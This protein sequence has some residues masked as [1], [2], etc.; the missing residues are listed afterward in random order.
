MQLSNN[1]RTRIGHFR[2]HLKGKENRWVK[3]YRNPLVVPLIISSTRQ[4]GSTKPRCVG[5]KG[6]SSPKHMATIAKQCK[7]FLIS[8]ATYYVDKSV[9]EWIYEINRIDWENI[10][11]AILRTL[12]SHQDPKIPYNP[13]REGNTHFNLSKTKF[14]LTCANVSITVECRLRIFCKMS[15][16]LSNERWSFEK[17]RTRFVL[18]FNRFRARLRIFERM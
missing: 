14:H 8:H 17:C 13:W 3:V 1:L 4:F 15:V 5:C 16:N 9:T 2:M 7:L 10:E 11:F 18:L 12:L 6:T